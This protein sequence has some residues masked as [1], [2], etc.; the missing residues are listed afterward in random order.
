[1]ITFENRF[2]PLRSA[3][4]F[5][6][7]GAITLLSVLASFLFLD[8]A[9]SAEYVTFD[10]AVM[11]GFVVAFFC[12]ACMYL[13]DLYDLRISHSFGEMFFSLLFAVGFVC[14]GIGIV[15]YF[16][17]EFGVEGTMYYLTIVF[18]V[19]FLFFWRVAFD[20]Y[21]ARLA[22]KERIAVVGT[23]RAASK[24][25][26]ELM[27][28]ERLGL[29]LV[30]FVEAP[31]ANVG[32][33]EKL[34]EVVGDYRQIGEIIRKHAVR[35]LVVAIG[36]RRGE[37]PVKEMLDARVRGCTVLEW[38]G[39]FERLSGRIPIDSLAPSFFI[40]NEGFRKS[41]LVLF[42]RR[43]ISLL[44]SVAALVILLP[45]LL[46]VAALI[47]ID[48]VGPVFYTQTRVGQNDRTFRIY[49][50]RSMRKNAEADGMAR[51]AVKDDPRV[52]RVGR[53]LRI[54][55][56]DELPQLLNVLVGDLD[57]VGPRPE[58]PEF[59]EE[60]KREIPY[61]S[62]RHTVKPGLTGWAQ[63]MFMYCGTIGESREKLQYDL[64]YIKNMSV[65]LDLY[66]LFRTLKIVILGRGAR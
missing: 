7:E 54:S 44:V 19:V 36:E 8:M 47:K 23:G 2:F 12:Q 58:R 30:G 1:M 63:V 13:L 43:V 40:F 15:S 5:F 35:K 18:V 57:L 20:F 66:I 37:Y 65:K 27:N 32:S 50:F 6:V 24:V 10:D 53:I 39:F 16:V 29:Q 11:R 48:S 33:V 62:L 45:L 14:I 60:L 41:K 9:G 56:I 26:S 46:V 52:T 25:A 49:K 3:I 31:G 28:R 64:F 59:V 21:L 55:R 51:W 38:P 17:P 4:C 61:Y 34:G 22:P 42:V